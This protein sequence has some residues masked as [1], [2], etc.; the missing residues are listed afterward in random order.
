MIRF[1]KKCLTQ[2]VLMLW[3][4]DIKL[5]LGK[6]EMKTENCN[7]TTEKDFFS[8]RKNKVE[9]AQTMKHQELPKPQSTQ[10]N[11]KTGNMKS[12]QRTTKFAVVFVPSIL[13]EN[14]FVLY[15]FVERNFIDTVS[16]L[17]YLQNRIE[18]IQILLQSA[19]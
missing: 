17:L 7:E 18:W 16:L 2:N 9:M 14:S 6:K 11:W 13:S 1:E 5:K 10:T 12:N 3:K 19:F 4:R 15:C 8:K